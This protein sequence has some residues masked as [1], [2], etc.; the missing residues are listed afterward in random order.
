MFSESMAYHPIC[1]IVDKG[2]KKTMNKINEGRQPATLSKGGDQ[3]NRG[4][5]NSFIFIRLKV[6][7]N[8]NPN[9]I[10]VVLAEAILDSSPRPM[11]R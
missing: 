3:C 7:F 11:R 10:Y 1:T 9:K 8:R 5:S 4:N 2:D 6:N